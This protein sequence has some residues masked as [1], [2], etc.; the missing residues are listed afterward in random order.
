MKNG[1]RGQLISRP[2]PDQSINALFLGSLRPQ[3]FFLPADDRPLPLSSAYT[4]MFNLRNEKR[5][6]GVFGRG[7]CNGIHPLN[8]QLA[9][10]RHQRAKIEQ[11]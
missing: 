8:V 3:I 5:E 2:C 7:P 4:V 6:R 9:F 10:S 1:G 11:H